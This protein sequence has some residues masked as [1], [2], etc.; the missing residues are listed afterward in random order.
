[1]TMTPEE[2]REALS[3][4]A[5]KLINNAWAQAR[6]WGRSPRDA[7]VLVLDMADA[8]ARE[9]VAERPNDVPEVQR[10]ETD[11]G[12]WNVAL[13]VAPRVR[14]VKNLPELADRPEVSVVVV[15]AGGWLGVP[16]SDAN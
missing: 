2:E 8:N 5:A 13:A 12:S 4:A 3:E 10:V 6:K 16:K 11:R 14:A 9:I 1:M 15:S 7:V